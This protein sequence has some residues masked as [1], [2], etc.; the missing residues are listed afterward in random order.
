MKVQSF[1]TTVK[2]VGTEWTEVSV[3]NLPAKYKI[4]RVRMRLLS[5]TALQA[6]LSIREKSGAT[7]LEDIALEYSLSTLPFESVESEDNIWV[8]A[9]D[10]DDHLDSVGTT[11]VAIKADTA[12]A[13][14][15]VVRINMTL[16][17]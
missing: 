13:N 7:N 9:Y 8:D 2:E 6:A 15:F 10:L 11:Y 16:E 5:G 14:V 12:D 4:D 3:S 17:E 1:T